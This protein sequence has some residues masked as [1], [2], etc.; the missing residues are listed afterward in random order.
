MVR[1]KGKDVKRLFCLS[2][3]WETCRFTVPPAVA[4][5]NY[6]SSGKLGGFFPKLGHFAGNSLHIYHLYHCDGRGHYIFR[7]PCCSFRVRRSTVGT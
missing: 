2:L 3:T 6:I 1:L 5:I 4:L 7:V